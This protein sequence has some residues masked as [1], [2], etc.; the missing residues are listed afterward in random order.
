MLISISDTIILLEKAL[1]TRFLHH[2]FISLTK[3]YIL[4]N[5]LLIYYILINILITLIYS[6]SFY[7]SFNIRHYTCL[8]NIE[9]KITV[10]RF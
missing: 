3:N 8:R 1:R 2:C 9:F 6:F 5:I 4:I 7:D 10:N